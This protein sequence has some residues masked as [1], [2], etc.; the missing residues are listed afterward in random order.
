VFPPVLDEPPVL[1][2][3]PR[4]G[5]VPFLEDDWLEEAPEEDVEG[6]VPP[7]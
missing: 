5:V 1:E 7:V 3:P 4:E 2:P 6:S